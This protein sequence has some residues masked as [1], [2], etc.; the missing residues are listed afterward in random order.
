[1]AHS[2]EARVPYLDRT[3]VDTSNDSAPTSKSARD[4][5]VVASAGLSELPAATY[6][7]RKKRGFAVNVVDQWFQSTLKA[8]FPN[9]YLTETL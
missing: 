6:P 8:N 9:C 3:V 4:A 1:M 5:Q 2:L 7:Q